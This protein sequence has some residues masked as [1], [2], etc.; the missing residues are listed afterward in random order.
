M[1]NWHIWRNDTDD[2]K[3]FTEAL[4]TPPPWRKR[5]KPPVTVARPAPDLV[6]DES[7]RARNWVAV[8][9]QATRDAVNMA[10]LLRR[11]L[12]VRGKPGLG[13]STLALHLA[14]RLNLGRPL[15]WEIGSRTTLADGLY[16]YDA[17]SHLQAMRWW[18]IPQVDTPK[19]RVADFITLGPLGTALLPTE[20]PR[21]LLIDE[22]DKASYDLPNDLL[23]VLEEG[24]FKIP[25]LVRERDSSTVFPN[26]TVGPDD[27]VPAPAGM[28]ET[29]RWPVVVIT[30]NDER[31]FPEAFNRRCVQLELALPGD[32]EERVRVTSAALR[33]W[34]N[35]DPDIEA[36]A[37]DFDRAPVDRLLAAFSARKHGAT[38]EALTGFI[39]PKRTDG[40][41]R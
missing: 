40:E 14:W 32:P 7:E 23:H 6:D 27:R 29:W 10:L 24:K 20:R 34:F 18:E 41:T 28:V 15:R 1:N 22:L 21:L 4:A 35:N 25:E 39:D 11:P 5:E 16:A 3:R 31:A 37:R 38:H 13:K 26:D 2:A 9:E 8:T 12:L 36:F 33:A 19:P 17:V 30:S